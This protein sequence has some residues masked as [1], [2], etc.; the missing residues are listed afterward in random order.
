MKFLIS[1]QIAAVRSL[2]GGLRV[3]DYE[4]SRRCS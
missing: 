2:T 4:P 3:G 1:P